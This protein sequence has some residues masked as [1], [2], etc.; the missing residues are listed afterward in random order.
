[1]KPSLQTRLGARI[2]DALLLTVIG[3]A[4]G[5]TLDYDLVWLVVHAFGSYGYFVVA[6]SR[7][8][9]TAGK[10]VFGL[11]VVGPGLSGPPDLAQAARREA[12]VLV[13]AVPF[14]GPLAAMVLWVVIARGAM[15]SPVGEAVHDRWAGGT[16]VIRA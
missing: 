12:F 10:A 1:M 11:R 9:R 4:W 8:G 6:D 5:R 16:R 3:V 15:R 13:G 2:V 7:F 14:F